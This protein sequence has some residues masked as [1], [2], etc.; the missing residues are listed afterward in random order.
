MIVGER[1]RESENDP[2]SAT[3]LPNIAAAAAAAAAAVATAAAAT[4][5]AAAA[6]VA[7]VAVALIA[8]RGCQTF[9]LKV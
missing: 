5:A 8:A 1:E 6:S 3:K 4:G 7:A 9:H 2:V